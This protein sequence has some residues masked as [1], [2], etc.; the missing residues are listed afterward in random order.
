M[1]YH[2]RNSFFSKGSQY[3][4]YIHVHNVDSAENTSKRD[5]E[6]TKTEGQVSNKLLEIV[7]KMLNSMEYSCPTQIHIV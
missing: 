7:L 6:Q 4:L 5:R 3:N 2:R 1:A